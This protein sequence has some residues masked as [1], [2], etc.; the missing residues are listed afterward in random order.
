MSRHAKDRSAIARPR[1][2]DGSASRHLHRR[3]RLPARDEA[4]L[5]QLLGVRRPRQ[6]DPGQRRLFHDRDRHAADDHG[7]SFRWRNP[8]PAQSLPAQ[9]NQDRD[10]PL[11]Q[12][13][14]VLPLPVPCLVIQDER[15]PSRD[16]AAQ[17]LQGHRPRRERERQGH[18]AGRRREELSRFRL[19][20][21]CLRRRL[22]RGVLRRFPQLNR[23]HGRP[24]AYRTA[25]DRRS[26]AALHASLQLEDAGREPDRHLPSHGCA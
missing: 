11:G 4:S 22:L 5:R 9:G 14:Q 8:C 2:S 20:A 13:R 1:P 15:L 25:R 10:R 12:Y 7:A 23:Q 17:G 19:R 3:G 21:P 16:P 26:A 18:G 24:V 6:P